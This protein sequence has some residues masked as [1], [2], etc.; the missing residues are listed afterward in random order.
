MKHPMNAKERAMKFAK[1]CKITSKAD[2]E[3]FC[4]ELKEF[5]P[6]LGLTEEGAGDAIKYIMDK[7]E[8]SENKS[9]LLGL[10]KK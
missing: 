9:G 8:K 3:K 4:A 10:F 1:A 6:K 5:L 7:G 2:A